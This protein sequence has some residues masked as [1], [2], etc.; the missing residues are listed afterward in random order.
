M[1]VAGGYRLAFPPAGGLSLFWLVGFPLA[2]RR[3]TSG[4]CGLSVLFQSSL[5]RG[6]FFEYFGQKLVKRTGYNLLKCNTLSNESSQHSY[7]QKKI[8]RTERPI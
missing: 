3:F 2:S 7:H 1:S 4:S 5:F 6:P 8:D